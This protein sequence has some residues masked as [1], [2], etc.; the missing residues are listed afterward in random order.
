MACFPIQFTKA[1]LDEIFNDDN[2]LGLWKIAK[3]KVTWTKAAI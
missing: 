2:V 3:E 1:K